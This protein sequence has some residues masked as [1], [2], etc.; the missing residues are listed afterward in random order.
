[1]PESNRNHLI[2]PA[3]VLGI[4]LLFSAAIFAKVQRDNRR[5]SQCI[6]ATG[7]AKRMIISDFGTCVVLL[8]G[9]GTQLADAYRDLQ[10]QK[11]QVLAYLQSKGFSSTSIKLSAPVLTT[12]YERNGNGYETTRIISYTYTQE[13]KLESSDVRAIET[14]SLEITGLVEQGLAISINPPQ[15]FYTKLADL[16]IEIQA[17]AAADAA[18]RARRIAEATGRVLGPLQSARMGVLQITPRNSNDIAD[19]GMNDVSSIEKEITAV[20]NGEFIIN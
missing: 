9:T 19:Y 6:E 17:E 11:P 18:L 1:M 3:V 7:S 5:D 13:I 20:V 16:K 8:S 4:A 12:N 2:A 14:L 15:Y 10:R